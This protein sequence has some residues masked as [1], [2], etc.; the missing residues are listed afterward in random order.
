[1]K[2]IK[3]FKTPTKNKYKGNYG[4]PEILIIHKTIG[5]SFYDEKT[6]KA[7]GALGWLMGLFGN[8]GSS[9]NYV[10]DRKGRIFELAPPTERTWHAGISK[11]TF[12]KKYERMSRDAQIITDRLGINPNRYSVGF[13]FECLANETYTEAQYKAFLD[14]VEY[15]SEKYN[16]SKGVA[17]LGDNFLFTHQNFVYYKPML[18]KEKEKLIKMG[19][20]RKNKNGRLKWLI[21][22]VRELIA[23]AIIYI[24]EIN[25][26]KNKK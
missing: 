15:L 26:I 16:W 9:A 22:K 7:G 2:D 14:L 12:K 20:N 24:N 25:E 1:M 17:D 11:A 18:D 4:E 19:E 3:I 6:G 23:Q 21:Q 13:E 10:I 8:K 5:K